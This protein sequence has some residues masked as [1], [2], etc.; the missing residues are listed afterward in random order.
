MVNIKFLSGESIPTNADTDLDCAAVE[1][2]ALDD[3]HQH[4][5]ASS[6]CTKDEAYDTNVAANEQIAS[7]MP[8]N[9]T[10]NTNVA[11]AAEVISKTPAG[12]G[13]AHFKKFKVYIFRRTQYYVIFR[14][15]EL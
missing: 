14:P 1:V 5:E 2:T 6:S 7:N 15:K 8:A 12:R 9:E 11:V 13:N 10:I 3:Q 4:N